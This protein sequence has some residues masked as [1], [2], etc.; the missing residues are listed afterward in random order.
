MVDP[1]SSAASGAATGGIAVD[2]GHFPVVGDVY[3]VKDTFDNWCEATCVAVEEGVVYIHY[4]YWPCSWDEWIAWPSDRIQPHGSQTC[5]V[6]MV[7]DGGVQPRLLPVP[8]RLARRHPPVGAA[9][10]RV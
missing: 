6:S 2:A 8:C 5:T 3:D 1:S 7:V 9:G 10:R 4:K